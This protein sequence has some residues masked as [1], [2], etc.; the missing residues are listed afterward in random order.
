MFKIP[1]GGG[2]LQS[3]GRWSGQPG[4]MNSCN[5]SVAASHH[6][7]VDPLEFVGLESMSMIT[8]NDLLKALI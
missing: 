6:A 3:K 5:A 1:K 4:T 8:W 7:V 2:G